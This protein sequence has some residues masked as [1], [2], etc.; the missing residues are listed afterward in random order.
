MKVMGVEQIRELDRR[1]IEDLGMPGPV[2][3]ENA[4]R[5]CAEVVA[6][7]L[8]PD[9]PRT[10]CVVCGK[11]NNGGDGFVLARYLANRRIGPHV[12]LL[13][14]AAG[15]SEDAAL[16][17]RL[18]TG[19][20]GRVTEVNSADFPPLAQAVSSCQITVDALLGT[21]ATGEPTG[22]YADAIR[23]MN[24]CAQRIVAVDVPSGLD[25]ESGR[26]SGACIRAEVTVTFALPK[27]GLYLGR[28]PDVTGRVIV[29]DIG[30]PRAVVEA[31]D[32]IGE[33]TEAYQVA[34]WLPV[35]RRT[36]HK[37]EAG[38]LLVVGGSAMMAGAAF[39]AARAG[40]VGGAGLVRLA[41]PDSLNAAAKAALPEVITVPLIQTPEGTIAIYAAQQVFE[42]LEGADAVALGPGIT[43]H[44]E[45][46][47]V[48]RDLI[49]DCPKPMVVDADAL[50]ALVDHLEVLKKAPAPR[51]LTPHIGEMAR[52]VGASNEDVLFGAAQVAGEF[53]AEHQATVV[54]K[55]ARTVIAGADGRLFINPLGNP[56]MA[57][58]GTGDVL[59]GLL[60][61]LLAEGMVP[62]QAAVSAVYLHSLAGD[63][64][65]RTVGERCMVAGDITRHLPEAFREVESLA[66]SSLRD[67]GGWC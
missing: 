52:L 37:G 6:S 11:G 57:T 42:E 15:L 44:H 12:F 66:V 14:Q 67:G 7:L 10:V 26:I 16:N 62:F 55:Q 19:G 28:G 54:L 21:G 64:A 3:M 18:F 2:L 27:A 32:A 59:T 61:S 1:A 35:R 45:A 5:G 56:G 40:L 63:L 24:Q 34:A 47:Q 33:L 38:R 9:G 31:S 58:G 53:A 23:L 25:A 4:G 22:L 51:V 49:A 13:G 60:G 41:L 30:I 8:M 17:Y 43:R 46:A 65:A 50:N 39:L 48:A 36:A 29:C 20:G